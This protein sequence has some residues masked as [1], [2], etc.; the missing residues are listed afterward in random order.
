MSAKKIYDAIGE[1]DDDIL[2]D[3][4]Q[5][6][7]RQNNAGRGVNRVPAGSAHGRNDRSSRAVTAIMAASLAIM[8]VFGGMI[9]AQAAGADV[10]GAMARWTEKI[11]RPE[12]LPFIDAFPDNGVI[13]FT[14]KSA[15]CI[16][17][18]LLSM[19]EDAEVDYVITVTSLT[20]GGTVYFSVYID[21]QWN[22]EE[23]NLRGA[24]EVVLHG[25]PGRSIIMISASCDMVADVTV[26]RVPREN[27]E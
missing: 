5:F 19:E 25:A 12:D 7:H 2:T 22:Q 15:S 24:G 10:F 8:F 27:M 4:E 21:G 14:S 3:T 13:E 17:A 26:T 20:G 1:I 6:I 9:T 18:T 11:F 16:P 23:R